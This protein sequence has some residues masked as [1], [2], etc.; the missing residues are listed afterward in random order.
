VPDGVGRIKASQ[1][2]EPVLISYGAARR[3]PMSA[4][5]PAL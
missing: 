2:V 3:S 4:G 1:R 5:R